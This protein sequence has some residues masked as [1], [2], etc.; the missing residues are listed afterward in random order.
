[1]LGMTFGGVTFLITGIA[2]F[3]M[4][5]QVQDRVVQ[6]AKASAAYATAV[7]YTQLPNV[8]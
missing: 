8:R 3:L 5:S 4:I 2:G 1:M 7:Q 6:E